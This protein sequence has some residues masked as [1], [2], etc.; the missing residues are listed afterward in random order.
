MNRITPIFIKT[1]SIFCFRGGAAR[2][3]IGKNLPPNLALTK[4]VAKQAISSTLESAGE[5]TNAVFIKASH[6]DAG[7]S[8]PRMEKGNEGHVNENLSRLPDLLQVSWHI[9]HIKQEI[10]RWQNLSLNEL[11]TRSMKRCGA[12]TKAKFLR[13]RSQ[14]SLD[15]FKNRHCC[16]LC[17]WQVIFST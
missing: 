16:A 12:M 10:T 1:R 3:A 6:T 11:A 7:Y 2:K 4:R 9:Y 8:W 15:E 17:A 13:A 14:R 5:S